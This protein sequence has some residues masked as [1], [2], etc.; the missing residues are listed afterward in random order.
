MKYRIIISLS[1]LVLISCGSVKKTSQIKTELYF[2]LSNDEGAISNNIWLEFKKNHIDKILNGYTIVDAYGYWTG[3]NG[4]KVEEATKILVYVH[5]K[6]DFESQKIDS[7]INLY[8]SKFKQESVLKI[9]QRI[10]IKF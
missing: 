1:F 9:E 10:K 7:I 5:K 2:G 3:S 8:K 6:S 4:T